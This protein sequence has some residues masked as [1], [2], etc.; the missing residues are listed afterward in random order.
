MT[1]VEQNSC[2]K[3]EDYAM[4]KIGNVVYDNLVD[5]EHLHWEHII[6]A[7]EAHS[8]IIKQQMKAAFTLSQGKKMAEEVVRG[9]NRV[10]QKAIASVKEDVRLNPIEFNRSKKDEK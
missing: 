3:E 9:L 6:F 7:L 8:E 2:Q 10:S 1:F 5:I 4:E